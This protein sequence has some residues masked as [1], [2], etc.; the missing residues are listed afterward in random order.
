MPAPPTVRAF[1]QARM[2]S[3]RFPGKVLAPLAGKPIV[4][5]VLDRVAEAVPK[6][7]IIVATST[8]PSD[9]PLAGYVERLGFAVHRGPLDDVLARFQGCLNAHPCDGFF[10]VCAD[11]PLLDPGILRGM[12]AHAG[13]GWDIVTNVQRRTFPT[14]QSAEL[15]GAATFRRLDPGACTAEQRE[16]VTMVYY[17]HPERFR[18]L[19]IESGRPE[20]AAQRLVVD[21]LEDLRAL[22]ERLAPGTRLPAP[23]PGRPA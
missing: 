10:R 16:H 3:S 6:A 13:G 23:A 20:L 1:I 18:I 8:H 14:G 5:H 22:E 4:A 7:D 19:N 12:L 2:S 17:D 9:D 15:L 21:T 11:S